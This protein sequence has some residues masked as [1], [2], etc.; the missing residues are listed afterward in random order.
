MIITQLPAYI[1]ILLLLFKVVAKIKG[2]DI[3]KVL[4]TVAD[5]KEAL[6]YFAIIIYIISYSSQDTSLQEDSRMQKG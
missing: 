1:I 2:V 3:D 5:T 4:R 6:Y